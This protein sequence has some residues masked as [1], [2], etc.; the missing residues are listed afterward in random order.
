MEFVNRLRNLGLRV[1]W[2]D[3]LV[4]DF[5]FNSV[6]IMCN[7][8]REFISLINL[9]QTTATEDADTLWKSRRRTNYER[10]FWTSLIC[11]VTLS[12]ARKRHSD[13]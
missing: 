8:I 5:L 3:S 7:I 13:N 12:S 11:F 10:L 9:T 6:S 2:H 1:K 4:I